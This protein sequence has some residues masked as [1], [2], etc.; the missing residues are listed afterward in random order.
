MFQV[1]IEIAATALNSDR[2]LIAPPPSSVPDAQGRSNQGAA[3][4]AMPRARLK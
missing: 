3:L 2:I 4:Y 1:V